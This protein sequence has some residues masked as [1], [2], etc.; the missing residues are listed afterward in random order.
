MLREL[1][2]GDLSKLGK[3]RR[4]KQLSFVCIQNISMYI[5]IFIRIELKSTPSGIVCVLIFEVSG[6][7]QTFV[8]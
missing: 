4:P 5:Y 7:S 3:N 8:A 1:K 2:C 6:G